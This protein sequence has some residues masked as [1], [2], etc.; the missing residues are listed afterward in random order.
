MINELIFHRRNL[1]RIP[2]LGYK[3]FKTS[4]Y[5]IEN[6]TKYVDRIERIAITGVV[7]YLNNNGN[8]T[9]LI[10]ADMDGLPIQEENEC[11]YKSLHEDVMHACGH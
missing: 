1:H 4:N 9:I 6:I 5:I 10:R 3:E 7:G 11:D 8:K 2:E